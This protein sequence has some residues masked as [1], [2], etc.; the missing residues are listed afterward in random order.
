MADSIFCL[1]VLYFN[2]GFV[3]GNTGTNILYLQGVLLLAS[4][5]DPTDTVRG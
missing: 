2:P 3:L 5:L 1:P 4:N